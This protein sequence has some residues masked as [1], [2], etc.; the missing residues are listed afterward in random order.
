[1]HK[2][3]CQNIWKNKWNA[4]R[5]LEHD[6]SGQHVTLYQHAQYCQ[7]FTVYLMPCCFS[8]HLPLQCSYVLSVLLCYRLQFRLMIFPQS[9]HFVCMLFFQN[10]KFLFIM[11]SKLLLKLNQFP[12]ARCIFR[13]IWQKSLRRNAMHDI[14]IMYLNFTFNLFLLMVI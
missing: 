4:I 9:C 2:N 8:G 3:S 12:W 14:N 1:M 13:F 7:E 11:N 5:I 10:R 6:N